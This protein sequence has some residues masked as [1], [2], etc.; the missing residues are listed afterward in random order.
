MST[1][2]QPAT[3][4]PWILW[5]A[6]L[7]SHGIFLLVG[8]LAHGTDGGV[9]NQLGLMAPVLTGF[10]L[11][12]ALA[13]ALAVPLFARTQPFFV[14]MVFRFALAES[15][16]IFGLVLAMLGAD[17]MWIYILTGLGATAHVAAM[18]TTRE[19]EAHE[20]RRKS[21]VA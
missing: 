5:G 14:A 20:Q 9:D 2:N 6:F 10:G 4:V 17:F 16:T 15:A 21:G 3:S 13:S 19:Q 7:V 18:P 12:T 1:E 8:H 11:V